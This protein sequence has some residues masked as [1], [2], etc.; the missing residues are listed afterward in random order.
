MSEISVEREHKKPT[1]NYSSSTVPTKSILTRSVTRARYGGGKS[2]AQNHELCD[3]C[4]GA[5]HLIC[6]D[7]CPR[8]YHFTCVNPPLD[9]KA[10]PPGNWYC[11][12]CQTERRAPPKA[13]P[14][15]FSE[16]LDH[17]RRVNSIQYEVPMWVKDAFEGVGTEGTGHFVDFNHKKYP[18]IDKF[19]YPIEPDYTQ[20]QDEKGNFIYCHYCRKIPARQKP[21]IPCDYCNRYWHLDCLNPPMVKRPSL[22]KKWMCPFHIDHYLPKVRRLK[23]SKDDFTELFGADNTAIQLD[24]DDW[25]DSGQY[26]MS[27]FLRKHLEEKAR[28]KNADWDPLGYPVDVL[29]NNELQDV[30]LTTDDLE[31]DQHERIGHQK[32]KNIN[33]D[34]LNGVSYTIN[35]EKNPKIRPTGPRELLEVT[36]KEELVSHQEN[37]AQASDL[38]DDVSELTELSDIPSDISELS[39]KRSDA[40]KSDGSKN[41]GLKLKAKYKET[42]S[43]ELESRKDK[44][45]EPEEKN[46]RIK[47]GKSKELEDKDTGT[48]KGKSKETDH[49]ILET[50]GNKPKAIEVK[51]LKSRKGESNEMEEKDS[52]EHKIKEPVSQLSAKYRKAQ[53]V[54]RDDRHSIEVDKNQPQSSTGSGQTKKRHITERGQEKGDRD[55]GRKKMKTDVA[56]SGSNHD[57]SDVDSNLWLLVNTALQ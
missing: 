31:T 38:S 22:F 36:N 29:K 35:R 24:P 54:V 42:K 33:D 14:S 30:F 10:P 7:G 18:K 44:L 20:F 5:G 40:S 4:H 9:Y 57:K 6:C 52:V 11:K 21:A 53:S 27:D 55:E 8:A 45:K 49:K 37:I 28:L 39:E 23:G 1:I 12:V 26:V 48:N 17:G 19:G 43:R 3:A 50:K 34:P 47:K 13:P 51:D 56:T 2:T 32:Y 25:D 46:L 16:L 15:L 41:S